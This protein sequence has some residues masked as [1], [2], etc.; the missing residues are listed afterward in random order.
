LKVFLKTPPSPTPVWTGPK[1]ANLFTKLRNIGQAA[2]HKIIMKNFLWGL[3]MHRPRPPQNNF[4]MLLLLM[5]MMDGPGFGNDNM[6]MMLLFMMMMQ[7][8]G[9]IMGME[10]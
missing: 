9:G 1:A 6:M 3:F 4:L 8:P 2:R 5:M 7:Q 10:A